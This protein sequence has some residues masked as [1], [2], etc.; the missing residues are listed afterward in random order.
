ML[1][2]IYFP[3]PLFDSLISKACSKTSLQHSHIFPFLFFPCTKHSSRQF[4]P[5]VYFSSPLFASHCIIHIFS[6]LRKHSYCTVKGLS[7]FSQAIC[8][9][10]E[11]PIFTTQLK[12]HTRSFQRPFGEHQKHAPP[13]YFPIINII[14]RGWIELFRIIRSF[15]FVKLTGLRNE[16]IPTIYV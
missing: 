12:F 6:S 13:K 16:T 8:P 1:L 14:I 3:H 5:I 2:S 7:L 10:I 4:N 11:F 15:G 9:A